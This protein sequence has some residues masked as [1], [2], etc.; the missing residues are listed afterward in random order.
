MCRRLPPGGR[1]LGV[2]LALPILGCP[3]PPLPPLEVPDGCQPIAF[4][5]DCLLPFPSDFY[6]VD[7]R[8]SFPDA[9]LPWTRDSAGPVDPFDPTRL[10][11]A[12]GF[13]PVTPILALFPGGIDASELVFHTG[14]LARSMTSDS[15][16]LLVD[17][18]TGAPIPHFAELDGMTDDPARRALF[19]RLLEPLAFGRRYVVGIHGLRRPDGT[20][21]PAPEGFRRLRDGRAVRDPA[22]EALVPVYEDVVF[23]AL[24]K[25][26]ASRQALILAWTF[27]V[28]SE[29]DA[30]GDMRAVRDAAIALFEKTPPAVLSA[31]E[32]AD[33][34]PEVARHVE[35]ELE[36]PLFLE[37]TEPGA[38]LHR[39]GDG[40]PTQNGV[41][42]ARVAVL[43][44]SSVATS[45]EPGRL[46][47][48]GHGFFGSREEIVDHEAHAPFLDRY[49][50]V[51]MSTDW[52]GM[53]NVDRGEVAVDILQD[54]SNILRFGD[55]V[56]QAM[57]NQIALSYAAG[58]TLT[59]EPLLQV[60][61]RPAYDAEHVYFY[62]ISQGH[63]LGGT[64]LA[65]APLVE[66]G[67]L[68]HFKL[69]RAVRLHA[70]HVERYLDQHQR[71][72]EPTDG[73]A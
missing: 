13:S 49:G 69:G 57:V 27:T 55:R 34:R 60:G 19:L 73:A 29:A 3:E 21:V 25:V 46:L 44:P 62:G 71:G 41:A 10:H 23:P 38:L 43:I 61:G 70:A 12:A 1:L 37:S 56:H 64:Y 6:R 8:L 5:Y 18:E 48:Y 53:S 39:D 66:R 2:L 26:G 22:L 35:I 50:F 28:R 42:T 30:T 58:T 40:R 54:T 16:T 9:A 51:S 17:A 14:D 72:C 24:E 31:R 11:P 67:V 52:W 59:Q 45:A 33:D 20:P 32:V 47:Q 7:G 68:P 4:E 36:V 63:I 65:L 15:P